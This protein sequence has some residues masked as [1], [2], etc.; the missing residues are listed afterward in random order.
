M[1]TLTKR[2]RIQDVNEEIKTRSIF[3]WS[4]KDRQDTSFDSLLTFERDDEDKDYLKIKELEDGFNK[5]NK[6]SNIFTYIVLAIAFIIMT[7][8]L[9]L[10]FTLDSNLS[11]IVYI[12]LGVGG[13]SFLLASLLFY[14]NVRKSQKNILSFFDRRHEYELKVKE[15]KN[16]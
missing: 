8:A 12:L 4:L 7:T 3:L 6:V 2:V 11:F 9:I 13:A 10:H 15:I 14:M 5:E 16:G 1:E